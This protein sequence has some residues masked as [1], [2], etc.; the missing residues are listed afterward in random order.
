MCMIFKLNVIQ[1]IFVYLFLLC[2]N[3]YMLASK[4][5]CFI[6]HP[7]SQVNPVIFIKHTKT[8]SCHFYKY[9]NRNSVTKSHISASFGII[10]QVTSTI[11]L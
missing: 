7:F 2:L 5:S 1:M 10:K 9:I 6:K 4:C 3:S 8:K 11:S